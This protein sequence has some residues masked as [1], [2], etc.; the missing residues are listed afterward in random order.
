MLPL[1]EYLLCAGYFSYIYILS[2]KTLLNSEIQLYRK[3]IKLYSMFLKTVSGAF[4]CSLHE[5]A[6]LS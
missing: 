5:L 3:N 4:L 1:F 6:H 2:L